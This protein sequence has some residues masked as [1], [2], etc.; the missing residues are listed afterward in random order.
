[1]M[2]S[3]GQEKLLKILY[4][5][6]FGFMRNAFKIDWNFCSAFEI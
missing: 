4:M 6:E 3:A 5:K 2:P 1:M